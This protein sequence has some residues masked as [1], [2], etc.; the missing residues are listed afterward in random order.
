[1][2]GINAVVGA[3]GIGK[4]TFVNIVIYCLVG[5][6]KKRNKNTKK[7]DIEYIDEDFFSS[8]TDSY[9]DAQENSSAEVTLYYY[10]GKT[11]VAITRSLMSNKITYLSI[12]D[13]EIEEVN[14]KSYQ[15]LVENYS[16][17]SQFQ[18]FELLV[19]EFL[20]FDERR[21]N[22]AWEVDNQDNILRILLLDEQ[23]HLKINE[24]EDMITKADTKGRH[25]SEDKRMVENSYKELVAER[26][27][28]IKQTKFEISEEKRED[29]EDFEVRRQRLVLKKSEAESDIIEAQ[30]LLLSLNEELQGIAE[31]ISQIEG[32][33]T[34]V[35][36][37]YDSIVSEIK[38][39]E[40][41]LYKS[42]YNK[43]PNYYYTLEKNLLSEGKCL[44]CNSRSK[45]IQKKASTMKQNSQ[46]LICSSVFTKTVPVDPN[47]ITN[48][49]SLNKRMKEKKNELNNSNNSLNR[50][51]VSFDECNKK[52][53]IHKSKIVELERLKVVI[54]S[55]LS[56]IEPTN[57]K[58]DMY[59]EILRNKE[60]VVDD[61]EKE[62]R[63]AYKDRDIHKKELMEYT[64]KFESIIN[65]LNKKLSEYFNKYASTFIGLDCK[66]AT[67]SKIINKIQHV[68]Y[69]PEID[70]KE[71][72]DIWSVSE[73]QR[74]FLD[75]AFRMAII[76]YLQ[77][78][79]HDFKTFF[80][81]ETPE[82]SLDIAYEAQVAM[83]F[84]IFSRSN[85]KIV[86]TSNLNS[87]SFLKELYRSVVKNERNARTLN[88]LK[89]GRITKVQENKL[90][91][92]E[93]ILT[94]IMEA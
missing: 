74:F 29:K 51:K 15:S 23:Y 7:S 50:L 65:K 13:K 18:D 14:E 37:T 19:R 72:K 62:I 42:I 94:E 68:Y 6:K 30:E 9:A 58:K 20:F 2:D 80:I 38:K 1:M 70:G 43:L 32:E 64:K 31:H 93:E 88:L 47:L 36:V 11:K 69:I 81:T 44:V 22:I 78:E 60:K 26:D 89:K 67:K 48:L 85:N 82:G 21:T 54:E 4:T 41:E 53:N 16:K 71:R 49:N 27:S 63:E 73:S 76:D 12:N 39:I 34:N 79:I 55:E 59:S 3:N 5:H 77:N 17:I 56:K 66:L 40:I 86:F 92:L 57:E 87:S 84:N 91:Q 33:A 35:S 61:L 90:G 46:C 45:E 8:R 24:L 83:M 28:V 25:K 75:Q 52:I 10:L